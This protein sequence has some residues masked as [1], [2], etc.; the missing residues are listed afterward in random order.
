MNAHNV[1]HVLCWRYSE[2]YWPI[3]A[4]E[5]RM[6]CLRQ[7]TE[8]SYFSASAMYWD[9]M[10]QITELFQLNPRSSCFW[11]FHKAAVGAKNY[12]KFYIYKHYTEIVQTCKSFEFASHFSGWKYNQLIPENKTPSKQ[13]KTFV[14][15][16]LHTYGFPIV[17]LS[18]F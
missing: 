7:F 12:C 2:F 17:K 11:T 14:K 9:F 3:I 6:P 5:F 10:R 18:C 15:S 1:G 16:Y 4:R 8:I 13:C